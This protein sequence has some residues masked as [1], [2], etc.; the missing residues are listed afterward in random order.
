MKKI[1]L[2][3]SATILFWLAGSVYATS[4]MP[5]ELKP[6]QI[7]NVCTIHI[8]YSL[9]RKQGV[10]KEETSSALTFDP[11]ISKK[12]ILDKTTSILSDKLNEGNISEFKIEC[13]FP[14]R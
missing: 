2:F 3:I 5:E 4:P 6:G 12:D 10:L 7:E 14:K 1:S 13:R 8:T 11:S 9:D